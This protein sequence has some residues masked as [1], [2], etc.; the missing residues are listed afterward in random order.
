MCILK[1]LNMK[2]LNKLICKYFGHKW[3]YSFIPSDINQ[4]KTDIR[5]CSCCNE[6]E[7]WKKYTFLFKNNHITEYWSCMI[8]YTGKGAKEKLGDK[9]QK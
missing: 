5:T 6:I 8:T 7:Y 4:D 3:I 2:K 1:E 9:Y